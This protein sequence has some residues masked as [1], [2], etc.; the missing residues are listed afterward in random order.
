M[1]R[2]EHMVRAVPLERSD[3]LF[4]RV[5]T[6][7]DALNVSWISDA[8]VTRA[9]IAGIIPEDSGRHCQVKLDYGGGGLAPATRDILDA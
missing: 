5:C 6:R 1:C 3:V 2:D 8:N 9:G 7:P 4:D